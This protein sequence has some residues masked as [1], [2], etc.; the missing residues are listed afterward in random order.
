MNGILE[1]RLKNWRDPKPKEQTFYSY[2]THCSQYSFSLNYY[3]YFVLQT[4]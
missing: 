1:S 2:Y 4:L 3:V